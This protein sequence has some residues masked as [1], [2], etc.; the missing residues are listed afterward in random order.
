MTEALG[1]RTVKM[2]Y[3]G[4]GAMQYPSTQIIFFCY[5]DGA[6]V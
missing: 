1:L 3:V 2:W 6:P 4:V 5:C